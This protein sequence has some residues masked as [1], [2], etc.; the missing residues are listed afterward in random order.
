MGEVKQSV[1]EWQTN[2]LRGSVLLALLSALT[3]KRNGADR[4]IPIKHVSGQFPQR[5][6]SIEHEHHSHWTH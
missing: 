4:Y 5:S 6:D 1:A 3:Y 2:K